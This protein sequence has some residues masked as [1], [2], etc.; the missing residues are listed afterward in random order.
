MIDHAGKI[1]VL[2]IDTHLKAMSVFSESAGQR[3][4]QWGFLLCDPVFFAPKTCLAV[5]DAGPYGF[6]PCG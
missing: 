3:I 1:G 2:V 4:G 5:Q 6:D